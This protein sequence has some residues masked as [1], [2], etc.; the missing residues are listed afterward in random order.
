MYFRRKGRGYDALNMIHWLL[1][2]SK[3]DAVLIIANH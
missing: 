3:A 1:A 2:H